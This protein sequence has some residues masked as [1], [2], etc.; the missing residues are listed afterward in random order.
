MVIFHSYVSIPEGI[1]GSSKSNV[2]T[3]HCWSNLKIFPRLNPGQLPTPWQRLRAELHGFLQQHRVAGSRGAKGT[4]GQG[5]QVRGETFMI[6]YIMV[7]SWWFHGIWWDLV[8]FN[9]DLMVISWDFIGLNGDLMGF[10]GNIS[11]NHGGIM[12]IYWN[13]RGIWVTTMVN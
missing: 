7:I 12:G 10:H 4:S 13:I 5:L 2:F 3:N 8:G 6:I 9:D 11:K 1:S